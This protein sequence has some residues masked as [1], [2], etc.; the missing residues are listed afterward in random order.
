VSADIERLLSA[1]DS[2]H[3]IGLNGVVLSAHQGLNRKRRRAKTRS[4]RR[5]VAI[6]AA[7]GLY[8]REWYGSPAS[9]ELFVDA[10][11]AGLPRFLFRWT[12]LKDLIL[13]R[14]LFHELGHHL[15]ATQAPE[16]AEPEDVAERW[17]MRLTRE[18]F[19]LL[20][21]RSIPILR[22]AARLLQP[23]RSWLYRRSRLRAP[24]GTN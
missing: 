23:V 20:H 13:A 3:L 7:H 9:I 24:R 18:A 16:H 4:R 11:L 12:T 2:R 14:V 6:R 5:K 21:P 10:M 19:A 15:H 17:R 1:L 8:H 22:T